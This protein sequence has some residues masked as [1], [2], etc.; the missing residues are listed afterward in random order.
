[1]KNVDATQ[2]NI[3]CTF[4]VRILSMIKLCSHFLGP[5][6][7]CVKSK[8]YIYVTCV[9]VGEENLFEYGIN[10]R[11]SDLTMDKFIAGIKMSNNKQ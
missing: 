4:G 8:I 9:C 10:E 1:M 2:Y 11:S 3:I 7:A 6:H 5:Y